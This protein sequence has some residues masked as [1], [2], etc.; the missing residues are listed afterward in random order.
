[1]G[2]HDRQS[3]KASAV[4]E[5]PQV[6]YVIRGDGVP[7]FGPNVLAPGLTGLTTPPFGAGTKDFAI[8]AEMLSSFL[9]PRPACHLFVPIIMPARSMRV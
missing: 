3:D 9:R 1:L 7:V 2:G 8:P 6:D 4:R 5:G